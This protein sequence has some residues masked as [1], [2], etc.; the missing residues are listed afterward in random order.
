MTPREVEVEGAP[1]VVDDALAL[2]ATARTFTINTPDDYRRVAEF[3]QGVKTLRA[4]IAETLDPHIRRVYEA[5]A[6]LCKEKRDAEASAIEAERIAKDLLV[7]WDSAQ[8]IARREEQRR[9]EAVAREVALEQAVEAEAAGDPAF[10]DVLLATIPAAAVPPLTPKVDGIRFTERWSAR[11]TD[12]G[13]FL[14]HVAAR[15]D[16]QPLILPNMTALNQ[17]ARSLKSRLSLPGVEAVCT[18]DV[19]SGRR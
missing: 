8:E 13:A 7:V 19:A 12:F 9:L 1:E 14:A 16:L 15:P 10:A 18:K 3:L 17:Q 2:V 11:V 6:A 5:H 4:R